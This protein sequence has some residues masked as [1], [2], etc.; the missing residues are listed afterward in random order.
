[1]D[2]ATIL[3]L[4][5]SVAAAICLILVHSTPANCDVT[6]P[7]NRTAYDVLEYYNLP[8]GLLPKGVIGYEL[9]NITGKFSA[10][11][12]NDNCSFSKGLEY[13]MKYEST[14][15]GYLSNGKM[16]MVEGVS[17][18]LFLVWMDIVKILGLGNTIDFYMDAGKA[19]FPVEHFED[20]PRCGC[21]I[22]CM[23]SQA[24]KEAHGK[25]LNFF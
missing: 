9:N 18:K 10:Y 22:N 5:I 16:S 24:T 3:R 17:M 12:M 25:S 11:L 1:M 6:R 7:R 2:S 21:S 13:Q 15:K 19:G 23:R 14:V 8:H 4:L 20:S